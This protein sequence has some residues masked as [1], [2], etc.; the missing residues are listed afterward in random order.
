MKEDE[1]T[2]CIVGRCGGCK[3]VVYA[4]ANEPQVMADKN[5]IVALH[6]IIKGGGSVEHMPV[7]DVRKS[8]FGCKCGSPIEA[9][10]ERAE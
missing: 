1:K 10:K 3:R 8:D 5:H 7:F 2:D 4:A 9:H 6:E